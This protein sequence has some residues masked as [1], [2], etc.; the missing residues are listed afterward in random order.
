MQTKLIDGRALALKIQEQ[1]ADQVKNMSHKPVLAVILV[2][3]N[4]ASLT[5]VR[6]KTK[7]AESVGIESR[8]FHLSPVMSEDALISFVRELNVNKDID[9]ILVQLPLPSHM[10]TDAVLESIDP[11]KDADGLHSV[12]LGKLFAGHP[13][14][15]PCTPMACLELIKAVCPSTEGMHAVIVGRSRL[16]GKPLAQ[17][18]LDAQCTVT[19]AHSRTKNLKDITSQA[20]ILISATGKSGLIT[21]DCVKSGAIVIDV[22]ITKGV[23]GCLT[24][25][26]DRLSVEGTAGALTPVPGGVGP[27]TITMLLKNV[28]SIAMAKM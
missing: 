24:G 15:V 13:T 10:N 19:Q 2:G 16:V 6:N 7:K 3:D 5:Y 4:P 18:L 20:D 1:L 17:L 21:K 8:L 9:G 27:M 14:L 12:N 25:D 23:D 28:V 11:K 26:V 22:G